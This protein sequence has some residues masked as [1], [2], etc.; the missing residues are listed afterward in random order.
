MEPIYRVNIKRF[1]MLLLPTHWRK[2]GL[3]A[4]VHAMVQ[5]LMG[6]IT[7]LQRFRQEQLV[8]LNRNGQVCKLRALI[9]S[10]VAI[11]SGNAEQSQ[12]I[13]LDDHDKHGDLPDNIVYQRCQSSWLRVS[14]REQNKAIKISRRGF[15]V[16][17]GYDFWVNIPNELRDKIDERQ[18]MAVIDKYKLAS[19]R[20]LIN[21][22]EYGTNNR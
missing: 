21:Y 15:G 5:P 18:L 13:T 9:R 6:H 11:M 17:K 19:K 14:E 1:A 22:I 10:V 8:E 2:A 7:E 16:A 20:Y 4:L 12:L 3:G